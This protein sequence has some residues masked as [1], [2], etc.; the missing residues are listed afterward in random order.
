[1]P[2]RNVTGCEN[3][4]SIFLGDLR[5]A[6]DTATIPRKFNKQN[7]HDCD[8]EPG[9]VL[10]KIPTQNLHARRRTVREPID[11][12]LRIRLRHKKKEVLPPLPLLVPAQSATSKGSMPQ[13]G[14]QCD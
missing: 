11:I 1:M 12:Q 9:R 7:N 3:M 8:P 4:G 10:E 6:T 13:T 14:A 5:G 2:A